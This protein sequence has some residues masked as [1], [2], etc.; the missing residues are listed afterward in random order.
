MSF[1]QCND[2]LTNLHESI[3]LE[4]FAL[5]GVYLGGFSDCRAYQS[6]TPPRTAPGFLDSTCWR[7]Y[8]AHFELG[9][10][11]HLT[12][13]KYVALDG[14]EQH[15]DEL[16]TG[17]F[18]L[19]LKGA[20]H[21]DGQG[22][23]QVPFEEGRIVEDVSRWAGD[24]RLLAWVRMSSPVR[25]ER[26]LVGEI[27]WFGGLNGKTGQVNN[28]GF[29]TAS[30]HDFYFHRSQVQSSTES[31][32]AGAPIVFKR[33]NGRNG[34][35]AAEAVRA[36]SL[37]ADEELVA[38]IKGPGGLNAQDTLAVALHREVLP[39]CEDEAFAAVAI[40][41]ANGPVPSAAFWRKFPPCSPKDVFYSYAPEDV[42]AT[43]CQR[44]YAPFKRAIA[45]LF[46]PLNE[47][48]TSLSAAD[49]YLG[50]DER[51][52]QLSAL[53]AKGSNFDATLA[54]M[55][56]ARAAEKAVKRFYE[57]TGSQVEDVALRQLDGGAGDWTTHDLI[58]DAELAID[59]KNARRPIY[60]RDFYVEHTVPKFK[61][62]RRGEGVAIAGVLSPYLRLDA[63]RHP[64]QATSSFRVD[65]LV[66]L[67]ETS[68]SSIDR[69]ASTFAS[70]QL[71]VVRVNERT[72]PNWVFG[73][74]AAWYRAFTERIHRLRKEHEWP[75]GDQWRYVF[76]DAELM[77]LVPALC[78]AGKPLPV[79][80][81]SKLSRQQRGF[82]AK[83]Q[84]IV[85]CPPDLPAIFLAVL[86]DFLRQV[87]QDD[88]DFSPRD[89]L[90]LLFLSGTA[91]RRSSDAGVPAAASYP[92][93]AIDP[94]SLV[95]T[96]IETF[97]TLWDG[98]KEANLARFSN[99]RFGGL[100]VLQGRA[101]SDV[102]WTT[103]VAYCG[104]TVY[105]SDERGAVLVNDDGEPQS[106]KGKCGQAPLILGKDKSCPDCGKLVCS[107]CR[108]CSV[109]CQERR[110]QKL[111]ATNARK[112]AEQRTPGAGRAHKVNAV[113]APWDE[114]PPLE[115]YGR[116]LGEA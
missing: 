89:Y 59:V 44:H 12:L 83:L 78:V 22:R 114:L 55:L 86:S 80:I 46:E 106:V 35:V 9:V 39:P 48:R 24:P 30:G 29:A 53:W 14:I 75:V 95:R 71:E 8:V 10:S 69:L 74:P 92:L 105:E 82:Y 93:G 1:R 19:D 61:L 94:L 88:P 13:R 72:V 100:G 23:I 116:D 34:Q 49:M 87:R 5:E 31:L 104:G 52:E 50:L 56:S 107:R 68:R 26:P 4:G 96:L 67:G 51:D 101:A 98:R 41:T 62:D 90:P 38:L 42:K 97:T 110:F 27:K 25:D 37:L 64:Q 33:A 81:S 15:L 6:L 77:R 99:F 43:V 63:I 36:L 20:D 18:W 79:T 113:A 40:L 47:F 45:D 76:D 65:D 66:F 28:Y 57:E 91:P 3:R 60:G 112:R 85:G 103:L 73:Y 16:L 2:L 58:V 102:A 54:K 84:E 115:A 32:F 109:L 111:A 21:F 11:G 70:D 17:R 108:F 7:G